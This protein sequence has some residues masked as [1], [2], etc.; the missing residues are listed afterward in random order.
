[1][2]LAID[3][4]TNN[5]SLTVLNVLPVSDAMEPGDAVTLSWKKEKSKATFSGATFGG[6]G[7]HVKTIR[8]IARSLKLAN[9][10]TDFATP[11]IFFRA[12]LARGAKQVVFDKRTSKF[13]NVTTMKD[14]ESVYRAVGTDVTITTGDEALVTNRLQR[15]VSETMAKTPTKAG[16]LAKWYEGGMKTEKISDGKAPDAV[17]WKT[18]AIEGEKAEPVLRIKAGP[19]K[20]GAKKA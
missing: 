5:A 16:A 3:I 14:G 10:D 9:V 17:D 2:R 4:Q 19:K 13:R 11:V 18:L 6:F 7:H 15:A 8:E 20:E 1:M 12:L